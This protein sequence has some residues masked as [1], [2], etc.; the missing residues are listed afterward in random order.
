[1][2]E[3]RRIF[4]CLFCDAREHFQ[5]HTIVCTQPGCAKYVCP[6]ESSERGICCRNM[7]TLCVKGCDECWLLGCDTCV[8]FSQCP[9]CGCDICENCSVEHSQWEHDNKLGS[10]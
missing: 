9:E 1:M 2:Q 7:C 8:T 3:E 6:V 4:Y 5:E 10:D